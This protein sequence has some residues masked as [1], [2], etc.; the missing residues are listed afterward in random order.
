MT[1]PRAFK[2]RAR[3]KEGFP[4]R[5]E[6]IPDSHLRG[7][8]T[9]APGQDDDI[10]AFEESEYWTTKPQRL[11]TLPVQPGVL[12][13]KSEITREFDQ[14]R[15]GQGFAVDDIA[16]MERPDL[17]TTAPPA[18]LEETGKCCVARGKWLL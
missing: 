6:R 18:Q 16:A 7:S 3:H 13:L 8:A 10:G 4:I 11:Q 12:R 15:D 2:I 5:I 9:P 1:G 17:I 14:A